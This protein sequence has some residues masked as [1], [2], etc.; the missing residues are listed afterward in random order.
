MSLSIAVDLSNS[1]RGLLPSTPPLPLP[2]A[3][4]SRVYHTQSLASATEVMACSS[5]VT[6]FLYTP[7]AA[8]LFV[9]S[10]KLLFPVRASASVVPFLTLIWRA[11]SD[12]FRQ[13]SSVVPSGRASFRSI[14]KSCSVMVTVSSVFASS[15]F[16]SMPILLGSIDTN[17]HS[18]KKES[19]RF[20]RFFP[21]KSCRLPS[22]YGKKA[23]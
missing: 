19:A 8:R 13:S 11:C 1:V 9:P 3:L 23:A 15:A 4:S 2:S 16:A 22:K 7:V 12:A 18:S 14:Y 20:P 10:F 6:S 21:V 17:R 5:A